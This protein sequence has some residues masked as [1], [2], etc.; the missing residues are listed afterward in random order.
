MHVL[1]GV[2]FKILSAHH[3]LDQKKLSI[4]TV[5]VHLQFTFSG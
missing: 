5:L 3:Y 2:D 4:Q 1:F